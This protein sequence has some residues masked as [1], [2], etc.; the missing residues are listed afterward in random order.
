M[1]KE[2]N[3]KESLTVSELL[4]NQ[5]KNILNDSGINNLHIGSDGTL[6]GETREITNYPTTHYLKGIK[7]VVVDGKLKINAEISGSSENTGSVI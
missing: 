3:T 5:L 2:E 1:Q 7:L 6:N 4:A